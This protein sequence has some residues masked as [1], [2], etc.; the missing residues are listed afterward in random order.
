MYLSTF[1]DL[2]DRQTDRPTGQTDRQINR[3]DRQT[4]RPTDQMIDKEFNDGLTG[5]VVVVALKIYKNL[6]SL[7]IRFFFFG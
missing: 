4:D 5:I 7:L 1:S 3:T 2:T 6:R